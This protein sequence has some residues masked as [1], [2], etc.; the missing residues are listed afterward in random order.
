MNTIFR[1]FATALRRF[2]FA[3]TLN[4][5]GLSVSFAAF[6]VIM[7]QVHYERTFNQ[8]YL[9][10]DRIYRVE[11]SSDSI[12]FGYS[13]PLP[14]TELLSSGI[15]P[16]IEQGAV[17]KNPYPSPAEEKIY[18]QVE[19][20]SSAAGFEEPYALITPEFTEIFDFEMTEG[21]RH[22]LQ[23]PNHIL[24]PESMARRLFGN[25]SAT[26]RQIKDNTHN[27][28]MMTVGG[29]YRDFP[30]NSSFWNSIYAPLDSKDPMYGWNSGMF[31]YYITLPEGI[32]P[33]Q[34]TQKMKDYIAEHNLPGWPTKDLR[35]TGIEELYYAE[36]LG[37]G[38][39][40]TVTLILISISLLIIIVAGINY[41]N[42]ATSLVPMRIKS[43]NT[44]KVLGESD[45]SLRLSLIGEAVGIALF[46]FGLALLWVHI[47]GLCGF[48]RF[49]L[50]D[51]SW[52][53]NQPVFWT[54]LG[55]ALFL[56]LLAGVYPAFYATKFSPALVLKGSFGLSPQ[57]KKLRTTLIGLQFVISIALI[58]GS[59][60]MY[61][62]NRFMISMDKG[63]NTER[64]LI[65]KLSPEIASNAATLEN[66]L[67]RNS[68][69]E[70]VIFLEQPFALSDNPS[71]FDLRLSD[72]TDTEYH[73]IDGPWNLP[74]F[75]N[76]KLTEGEFFTEEMDLIGNDGKGTRRFIFNE[77]ARKKFNL[78]AGQIINENILVVGIVEDFNYR[79]LREGINPMGVEL[80]SSMP[81][82]FKRRRNQASL[83]VR[84]T[85]NPTVA[86]EHIKNS[87]K[88][89]DPLY[90]T[91]VDFYDYLEG[92]TYAKERK[93]TSLISIFS[94]LAV[95]ISLV[96]V[97]G[98][99]MFETQYR[100]KEIGIRKVFGSTVSEVLAM[101]NKRFTVIVTVCFLLA[102]PVAYM[103]ISEW[104]AS[105]AFKTP[106]HGWVFVA[107]LAVITTLTL[108]TV[109]I[110][111]WKAATANPVDALRSE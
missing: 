34:V 93:T 11:K 27:G 99:V 78:T 13:L 15:I 70:D 32:N 80:F 40:R 58:E 66:L 106:M 94:L 103:F 75:L 57:G 79:P 85:G 102:S 52:T 77:T 100:S 2:K 91:H 46:S 72:G 31:V 101:F 90:P 73:Q 30:A 54:S 59:A 37:H 61:L 23:K 17:I 41:I 51:I 18:I 84:Y 60:F 14:L 38:G 28:V 45:R 87:I 76:L 43:I 25:S 83:H 89:I 26:G 36:D 10:S 49:L 111:S 48:N 68:A 3:S 98:L 95:V 81:P 67:K 1:N 56:G 86:I 39:S 63:R 6:I 7:M 105:F 82:F 74:Q 69:I 109:T 47:L 24:I 20:N 97:F 92:M 21:E 71:W 110:Q 22:A 44:K 29:V 65:T 33:D 96:G 62:Q 104:L 107:A 12:T 50:S 64:I 16:E 9:K 5:L 53:N 42:F 35:L 4:I 55:T 108:L 88:E 8:S 19:H